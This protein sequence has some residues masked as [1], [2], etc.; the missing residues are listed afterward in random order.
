MHDADA[1]MP[2]VAA[3]VD[4]PSNARARIGRCH[5]VQILP[6]CGHIL[7]TPHLSDFAPV[8]ARRGEVLARA[9]TLLHRQSCRGEYMNGWRG[10]LAPARIRRESDDVLHG[11]SERVRL[12]RVV[13]SFCHSTIVVGIPFIGDERWM[14]TLK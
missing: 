8:H 13:A 3:L 2:V 12:R 7:S 9:I 10:A 1:A 4:K 11:A 6:V 14:N 5:S